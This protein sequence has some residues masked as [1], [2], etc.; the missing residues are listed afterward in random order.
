MAW[1]CMRACEG[2]EIR[3]SHAKCVRVGRRIRMAMSS[4]PNVS[5]VGACRL[6][7][8]DRRFKIL[9]PPTH[10]LKK[11]I[12]RFECAEKTRTTVRKGTWSLFRHLHSLLAPARYLYNKH[13]ELGLPVFFSSIDNFGEPVYELMTEN[14]FWVSHQPTEFWKKM[15]SEQKWCIFK[16]YS[17]IKVGNCKISWSCQ[18]EEGDWRMLFKQEKTSAIMVKSR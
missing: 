6:K 1:R 17:N 15:S 18:P 9:K 4:A 14:E 16:L 10:R 2:A 11:Y 12:L 7:C 3:V 8:Q 5:N 13:T